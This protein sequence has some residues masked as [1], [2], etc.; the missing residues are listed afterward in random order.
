MLWHVYRDRKKE[1][2]FP[3]DTCHDVLKV[4]FYENTSMMEKKKKS[5]NSNRVGCEQLF[6]HEDYNLRVIRVGK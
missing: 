5:I 3:F 1:N 4:K 2:C 6:S